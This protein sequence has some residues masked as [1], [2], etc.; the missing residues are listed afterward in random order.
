[1]SQ[2]RSKKETEEK[3]IFAS[4]LLT[5]KPCL[6][7]WDTA[8]GECHVIILMPMLNV[9]YSLGSVNCKCKK[10]QICVDILCPIHTFVHL[11]C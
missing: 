4:A 5:L 10:G 7:H 6:P 1:M 2:N 8:I 9:I 11:I 3:E